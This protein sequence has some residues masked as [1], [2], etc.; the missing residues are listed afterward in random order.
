MIRNVR[1]SGVEYLKKNILKYGYNSSAILANAVGVG[2]N[3]KFRILDGMHRITALQ[4]LAKEFPKQWGDFKPIVNLYRPFQ[5]HE[6]IAIAQGNLIC[7]LKS[8]I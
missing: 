4:E 6:E 3:Q 8:N 5:R 7:F 2:E 1:A